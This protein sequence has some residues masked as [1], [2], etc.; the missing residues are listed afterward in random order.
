MDYE[1]K[2]IVIVLAVILVFSATIA[3]ARP[4]GQRADRWGE[5]EGTGGVIAL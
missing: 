2:M 3:I 1:K 5:R 4:R